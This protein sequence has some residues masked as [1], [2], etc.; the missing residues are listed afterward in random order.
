MNIVDRD[1]LQWDLDH[2]VLHVGGA[3]N[4][5]QAQDRDC[6]KLKEVVGAHVLEERERDV[7]KDDRH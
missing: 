3:S 5:H 1:P 2:R 4:R 6:R 7:E